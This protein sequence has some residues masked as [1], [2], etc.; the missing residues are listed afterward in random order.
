MR[1]EGREKEKKKLTSFATIITS[2]L[3]KKETVLDSACRT[4]VCEAI[5]G[6]EAHPLTLPIPVTIPAPGT[7][8][9]YISSAAK[10]ESSKKGEKGS[11][12]SS[13]LN[14]NQKNVLLVSLIL[15]RNKCKRGGLTFHELI[16]SL[17]LSHVL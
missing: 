16:I 3:C 17:S 10:G 12:N 8:P 7:F 14:F 4:C 1:K 13:I 2:V 9:P 5:I 6:F 15:L 11:N